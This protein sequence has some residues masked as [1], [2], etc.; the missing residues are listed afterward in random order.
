MVPRSPASPDAA[1]FD[2]ALL[3][4]RKA[5]AR[6]LALSR[7]ASRD[8]ARSAADAAA[9]A[10]HVLVD[11]P[12]P[13]GAV[14]AGFWPMGTEIDIRPLLQALEGRSHA[15]ALP[16][17]PKRGQPLSF[18]RWRFGEALAAGPMGT[19]QPAAGE[20]VAP[21]WLLVP[22]L[23]FDRAGRRL[24]YGGGYYDRTLPDLPGATAIGCGFT[25]QEMPEVPAGPT[26]YRLP[27]IATEAGV[28]LCG[29]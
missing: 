20:L 22:L 1:A 8:P 27:R 23:A 14:V 6:S 18:R 26:D 5:E 2:A 15:L 9:L 24:G 19:R 11:C 3:R 16:V 10:A 13:P 28:I 12:P 4:E 29:A 7:R 21:D 17:T 25:A